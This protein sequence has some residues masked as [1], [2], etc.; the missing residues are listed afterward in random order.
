MRAGLIDTFMATPSCDLDDAFAL[1]FRESL[2]GPADLEAGPALDFLRAAAEHTPTTNI[3]LENLIAQV[4]SAAPGGL[5]H[6]PSAER[7]GHLGFITQSMSRHLKAGLADWRGKVKLKQL[8]HE[9]VP[10]RA[11]HKRKARERGTPRLHFAWVNQQ[12]TKWHACNTKATPQTA[13]CARRNFH[14]EW[15][16]KPEQEK[17]ECRAELLQSKSRPKPEDTE[18]TLTMVSSPSHWQSIIGD[19]RWPVRRENVKDFVRTSSGTLQEEPGF[20]STFRK[21]RQSTKARWLIRN[22]GRIPDKETIRWR[23]TCCTAHFGLC[24]TRDADIFRD[25]YKLGSFI[26]RFFVNAMVGDAF[27]LSGDDHNVDY[28]C[29]AH[30]RSRRPLAQTTHVFAVL[31]R[32]GNDLLFAQRAGYGKVF[33]FVTQ[34]GLAKHLFRHG[35]LSNLVVDK[36]ELQTTCGRLVAQGDQKLGQ[37]PCIWPTLSNKARTTVVKSSAEAALDRLKTKG[38]SRTQQRA[39]EERGIRPSGPCIDVDTQRQ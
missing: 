18:D 4:R 22:S 19:A 14:A 13:A 5:K 20:V 27:A 29:L 35:A 25:A 34:F 11:V 15:K 3:A 37:G 8:L 9:G 16:A 10:V 33:W 28:V 26:E 2:N 17:I 1:P 7:V 23:M 6:K 39:S 24:V 38:A 12:M 21:V 32:R 36:L 31:E 30:V